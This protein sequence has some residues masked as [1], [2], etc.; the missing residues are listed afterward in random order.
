[1]ANKR[2]R[3]IQNPRLRHAH[4]LAE[5]SGRQTWQEC[6]VARVLDDH[7][8]SYIH[9][10]PFLVKSQEII[11]DFLLK[12]PRGIPVAIE[13]SHTSGS[14]W[15]LRGKVQ[16]LDSRFGLL[17]SE[18]CFG[19]VAC[20]YTPSIQGIRRLFRELSKTLVNTDVLI[21]NPENSWLAVITAGEKVFETLATK[22]LRS[23]KTKGLPDDMEEVW[24]EEK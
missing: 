16:Q 13:C 9:Q 20:L 2:K 15:R 3:H 1:M 4:K 21:S 10:A 6:E 14:P 22:S 19:S 24:R 8:I 23:E 18:L 17:K 11:L 5:V 12:S 7:Q